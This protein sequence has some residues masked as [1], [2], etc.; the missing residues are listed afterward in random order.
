MQKKRTNSMLSLVM[1][2]VYAPTLQQS[3]SLA[4]RLA[5]C[6]PLNKSHIL[7]EP[8]FPYMCDNDRSIT[9]KLCWI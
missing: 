2:D 5:F 3:L 6:I 9:L 4:L 8:V 1:E 7:Q